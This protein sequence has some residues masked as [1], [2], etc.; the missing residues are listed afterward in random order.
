MSCSR[1]AVSGT[2]EAHGEHAAGDASANRTMEQRVAKKRKPGRP[3]G[4]K[5]TKPRKKP[6][7]L[8]D[9]RD[10]PASD[11]DEESDVGEHV[12]QIIAEIFER[13]TEPRMDMDGV[14]TYD[15]SAYFDFG[16]AAANT[17]DE[18]QQR[19]AEQM[20]AG[21]KDP[22]ELDEK[23]SFTEKYRPAVGPDDEDPTEPPRFLNETLTDVARRVVHKILR[24]F[25][26]DILAHKYI[27]YV[28]DAESGLYYNNIAHNS[29]LVRLIQERYENVYTGGKTQT[30]DGGDF[31]AFR[32]GN[33]KTNTNFLFIV[34]SVLGEDM[35]S[36]DI[37]A[38]V[39]SNSMC[40]VASMKPLGYWDI[41]KG[42]WQAGPIPAGMLFTEW[43]DTSK[44][45]TPDVVDQAKIDEVDR[46]LFGSMHSDPGVG[47]FQKE[48]F[49]R[50]ICRMAPPGKFFLLTLDCMNRIKSTHYIALSTAFGDLIVSR[51]P[52]DFFAG[53]NS[54]QTLQRRINNLRAVIACLICL[55]EFERDAL[56]N[57]NAWKAIGG[58]GLLEVKL[59]Y[60]KADDI[61][62]VY[63]PVTGQLIAT[64]NNDIFD[65]TSNHAASDAFTQSAVYERAII[66][67]R[68]PLQGP[69]DPSIN[70]RMENDPEYVNAFR[71]LILRTAHG[72]V[73][74]PFIQPKTVCA[75]TISFRH[76]MELRS[77]KV[78]D[79][80]HD[81]GIIQA[82]YEK[83]E[84]QALELDPRF[85]VSVAEDIVPHVRDYCT[86]V[87]LLKKPIANGA[88]LNK[89][90]I[91]SVTSELCIDLHKDR[92]KPVFKG[93]RKLQFNALEVTDKVIE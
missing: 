30:D 81:K 52:Q 83:V 36:A 72:M 10:L 31:N 65:K 7:G 23:Y 78:A 9:Y 48:F 84:T 88:A 28:R 66:S 15:D 29:I 56:K 34:A 43:M 5:D 33:N 18:E 85:T 25:P 59:P 13:A 91:D 74:K 82:L 58:A 71:H 92:K 40:K 8:W 69:I 37:F 16:A 70:I 24:R 75:E 35:Y 93:L 63:L 67:P 64:A 68:E 57:G 3:K 51:V 32:P 26:T 20:L 80:I 87:L 49:A 55:D 44:P 41:V 2:S 73:D 77:M 76:A 60:V 1:P 89:A 61:T 42:A 86:K 6:A 46:W 38:L 11:T 27:L 54:T 90:V 21:L 62:T 12:R 4:S 17:Y 47:K 39:K 53:L 45:F 22:R 14:E 19:T 79:F 50:A